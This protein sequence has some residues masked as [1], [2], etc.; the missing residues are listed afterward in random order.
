M[1]MAF[2]DFSFTLVTESG[3][4]SGAKFIGKGD[5]YFHFREQRKKGLIS[6]EEL[7]RKTLANWQ[8]LKSADL[9]KVY[10]RFDFREGASELMKYL[11]EKRIK[12][13]LVTNVP[14]QLAEVIAKHLKFD[15]FIGTKMEVKDG[16]FTGKI[17]EMSPNKGEA[18]KQICQKAGIKPRDCMAVGDAPADIAMFEK[19][20]M[21]IAI[22]GSEEVQKAADYVI[23]DFRELI[24]II[25]KQNRA[26]LG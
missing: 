12:K 4:N 17:L 9:D 20:G 15:Y 6:M 23:D 25:E 11:E 19:V 5:E 13:A 16:V 14:V 10:K 3:L 1:K 26:R 18:V 8:G 2:F 22:R 24:E 21:S 7:I